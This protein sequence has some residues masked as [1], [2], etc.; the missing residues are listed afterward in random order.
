MIARTSSSLARLSASVFAA[1]MAMLPACGGSPVDPRCT[2][3]A[4]GLGVRYVGQAYGYATIRIGIDDDNDVHTVDA[5]M[6]GPDNMA[7]MDLSGTGTCKDGILRARL[8]GGRDEASGLRVLGAG[9]IIL[10]DHEPMATVVGFW[11]VRAI[12]EGQDDP[13]EGR[14]FRGMLEVVDEADAPTASG[15]SGP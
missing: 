13:P 8:D 7:E 4:K 5:R 9:L 11:D 3:P 6:F 12:R 1:A 2:T 15:A 14:V 10:F